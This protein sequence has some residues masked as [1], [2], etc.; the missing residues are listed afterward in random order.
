[1]V[2]E[3]K[4]LRQVLRGGRANEVKLG[5]GV[6]SISLGIIIFAVA[7]TRSLSLDLPVTMPSFTSNDQQ[8]GNDPDIEL[9]DIGH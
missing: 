7:V 6:G 9:Y 2:T 8:E 1:M 5:C 3:K 4:T